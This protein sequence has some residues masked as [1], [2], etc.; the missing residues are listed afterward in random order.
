M[1]FG[2]SNNASVTY[3][4][5]NA[6]PHVPNTAPFVT[7]P[8]HFPNVRPSVST[9]NLRHGQPMHVEKPDSG[10]REHGQVAA[11]AL[12]RARGRCRVTQPAK[13]YATS[14]TFP[15]HTNAR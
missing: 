10:L 3:S 12:Y 7:R 1:H 9:T 13:L 8:Q 4:I 6:K 11:A 14:T 15:Q 2:I 5:T